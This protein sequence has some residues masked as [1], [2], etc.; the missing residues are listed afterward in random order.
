[1]GIYFSQNVLSDEAFV[2]TALL[3]LGNVIDL[4]SGENVVLGWFA[5]NGGIAPVDG[6]GTITQPLLIAE[7]GTPTWFDGMDPVSKDFSPGLTEA[8]YTW[9]W[10]SHPV[11]MGYSTRW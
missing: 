3:R 10:V 6:G 8:E 7:S 2:A 1:M 11:R 9:S 4:I 5:R